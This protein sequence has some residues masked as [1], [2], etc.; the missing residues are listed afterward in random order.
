MNSLFEAIHSK[1][2]MFLFSVFKIELILLG[3]NFHFDAVVDLELDALGYL[4][5]SF[6][7]LAKFIERIISRLSC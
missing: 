3:T 1:I 6:V 5:Q 2:E 4:L 7:F